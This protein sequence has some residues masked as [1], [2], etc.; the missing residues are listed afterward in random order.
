[1]CTGGCADAVHGIVESPGG[2]T[3]ILD[4]FAKQEA[5]VTEKD[6]VR[7]VLSSG[8]TR[9]AWCAACRSRRATTSPA[10]ERSSISSTIDVAA[11][12][13][14]ARPR[15]PRRLVGT[16]EKRQPVDAFGRCPD[17]RS[18]RCPVPLSGTRVWPGCSPVARLVV[19]A[20]SMSLD[21]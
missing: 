11:L 10:A 13:T 15:S 7:I 1:M 20:G 18:P 6:L 9:T 12:A 21:A 19:A 8:T 3:Y 14:R 4:L 16:A 2:W 5:V 17:D